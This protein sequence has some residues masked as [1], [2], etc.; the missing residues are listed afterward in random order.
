M[1]QRHR[2]KAPFISGFSILE[3]ALTLPVLLFF[4]LATVD[5]ATIFQTKSALQEAVKTSLRCA[6][7]IEG[8]CLEV[9]PDTRAPLFDWERPIHPL[10]PHYYIPEYDYQGELSYLKLPYFDLQ[11]FRAPT[12]AQVHFDLPTHIY[13]VPVA[14]RPLNQAAD[15]MVAR[16]FLP[17]PRGNNRTPIFRLGDTDDSDVYPDATS[18]PPSGFV[19]P[20][21]EVTSLGTNA[22]YIDAT[23]NESDWIA[24]ARIVIRPLSA[25][26]KKALQQA[27]F[28]GYARRLSNPPEPE[29]DEANCDFNGLGDIPVE[30]Q[31]LGNTS[32]TGPIACATAQ[33]GWR[34]LTKS[35]DLKGLGGT[36]LRGAQSGY[37][38]YERGAP[39]KYT[40][41]VGPKPRAEYVLYNDLRFEPNHTYELVIKV[42]RNNSLVFGTP[43]PPCGPGPVKYTYTGLKIFTPIFEHRSE[44]VQCFDATSPDHRR[45]V[46]AN[47]DPLP[48]CTLNEE[49][50][51]LAGA[52]LDKPFLDTSAV[53]TRHE[54]RDITAFSEAHAL[55][56]AHNDDPR[57]TA[58]LLRDGETRQFAE[59]CPRTP[60]S[61]RCAQSVVSDVPD[62]DGFIREHD[63]AIEATAKCPIDLM[64]PH[65]PVDAGASLA[66]IVPQNV[67]WSQSAPV[68]VSE[69]RIT[70]LKDSCTR[71]APD[72]A[73]LPQELRACPE[74]K[75]TWDVTRSGR[76]QA[77]YT[78]AESSGYPEHDPHDPEVMRTAD[79]RYSCP[80]I[81]VA[82]LTYDQGESGIPSDSLFVGYH[83]NF[84]LCDEHARLRTEAEREDL[85]DG[86]R[87]PSNGFFKLRHTGA[88]QRSSDLPA[89]DPCTASV[90][91]F[92][93]STGPFVRVAGGPYPAGVT[94]A[95]C[96]D[97][98][99]GCVKHFAGHSGGDRGGLNVAFAAAQRIGER[100]LESAL[101][102]AARICPSWNRCGTVAVNEVDRA[103][104]LVEAKADADVRLNVL[105]GKRITLSH[106]AE[107]RLE[108]TLAGYQP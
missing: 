97:P 107:H 28:K 52:L 75:L 89:N 41:G 14:L 39:T 17:Y 104:G 99:A 26:Y 5:L 85:P 29:F 48:E 45:W 23:D 15:F 98:S 78:G 50:A 7:P 58:T 66:N 96:V 69:A 77:L 95:E 79:E 71:P 2:S 103:Q 31:V 86:L 9:H 93:R 76:H 55:S 6:Y 56:I 68:S 32:G 4:V 49:K 43:P 62:A 94:P 64:A 80:E 81:E 101:P 106:R 8:N 10:T 105:L 73:S 87:L 88:R 19:M 25:D 70:W 74:N 35:G 90:Q 82:K 13:R 65:G 57:A 51:G 18:N 22:A 44:T 47:A 16:A 61:E 84:A 1:L 83:Q 33:F 11:N 27:C 12:L 34:D 3:F 20:K 38:F 21:A 63:R 30:L 53:P 46:P 108:A 100:E 67:R 42:T 91:Q 54:Y 60:L 72:Y 37:N 40:N 102:W 92:E 24:V 36:T 59:D